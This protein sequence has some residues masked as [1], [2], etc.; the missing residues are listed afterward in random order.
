V[1]GAISP[2][3][4]VPAGLVRLRLVNAANARNYHLHFSDGREFHVIAS[5]GGYI[6]APA[7]MTRLTIAP[8]ERYEIL[9][10][11]SDG[12]SVSLDTDAD[13]PD[14]D[15]THIQ[16]GATQTYSQLGNLR[17]A[18]GTLV[19]FAVDSALPVSAA[20]IPERLVELEP[21]DPSV[22]VA[23]R[24]ITMDMWPG[25]GGRVGA[26]GG[27]I[28]LG[29]HYHTA[30]Q[31]PAMGINGRVF[32]MDR[33]DFDV[34]LGSTEI[35]EVTGFLMPHPFHA[36]GVQFRVLSMDGAPPPAHLTGDKD[37]LL[38]Q[39][40]VE[41]LVEFNQPATEEY[42]FMLHC[43]MMDHEEAGMMAQFTVS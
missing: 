16:L 6:P 19:H 29:M 5:D 33:I 42:P 11:F 32:D 40:M 21:L 3:A 7:P 30:G 37:T 15:R 18:A 8:G 39:G 35:W 13:R 43:H 25:W 22:A 27:E 4:K 10:D 17:S 2:Q 12:N 23:R 36:H 26:P 34:A 9:V 28:G 24:Q 1:N 41:L 20:G 31:G 38:L 14:F